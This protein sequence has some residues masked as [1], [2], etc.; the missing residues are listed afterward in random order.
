M[1]TNVPVAHVQQYSTIVNL[2]LQQKKSRFRGAV[3]ESPQM[4]KSSSIVEQIGT[5]P[6]TRN[7]PRHSDTGFANVAHDK[8][9]VS[10]NDYE[11]AELVDAQ[12]LLRTLIDPTGPY[13]MAGVAAANRA[14]DDEVVNG[15]FN[16][17][18]TGENGTTATATLASFG[19]G[20]QM[21]A[22]TVGAAAATGLNVAKLR[23][24]MRLLLAAEVDIESDELFVGITALQHDN[25]LNETQAINLDY[26]SKPILEDGR[27]RRFMGFTF[28]QSERI[29]GGAGY[30]VAINP[31]IPTGSSDGQYTTGSRFMVPFWAKSGVHLG[32]WGDVQTR[33]DEL[34]GKRYAT[35]VYVKATAG[36]T[37]TQEKLCGIIN[38]A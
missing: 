11:G 37:R 7:A 23:A 19:S 31:S 21:V 29:P 24:A 10:P 6:L 32:V 17:N 2:L 30:N 8:R 34:P 9:W 38:C 15:F 13:A 16:A 5:L 25:M 26:Q 1:S 35:Q 3:M 18:F 12:D 33:I 28:I 27:I 4:G 22:A 36:A 20:S 14:F